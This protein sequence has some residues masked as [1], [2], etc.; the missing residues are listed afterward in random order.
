MRIYNTA[1]RKKEELIPLE[2]GH[3]KIYACGPT[4]YDLM[5][6]GNAR[7]IITFDALRRYLRYKGYKVTYV[8]NF[9]D[10]DDKMIA[11]SRQKG[12][13]VRELADQMIEEYFHDADS[14][15][16]MR[17]DVHPRATESIPAIIDLITSL[18][19]KGHAYVADDGVYFEVASF[20]DYGKLSHHNLED[21]EEGAS[22]RVTDVEGKRSALDFVLWKFKKEGE[23]SWDSPW[24]AGRPGWHIECSAMSQEN[25]GETI[26]IHSG[27]VDLVFPHHENEIAQSEAASGKPFVRYWMHNGFINVNQIKMSK[28]KGNFF[29]V[30]KLAELYPYEIIRYYILQSHYR[31]PINFTLSDDEDE[32]NPM[33]A[34][35]TSYRRIR[36]SLQTLEFVAETAAEV[37]DKEIDQALEE[38]IATCR[39]EW[40]EAMD[41]DLNTADA[42]AAIFDL[43]R[44]ANTAAAS[45]QASKTQ[46]LNARKT[47][48]ELCH[49]L[50]L[51]PDEQEEI[52]IPTEVKELVEQRTKAKQER[53]FEEADRL[54]DEVERLGFRLEDTPQGVNIH[55]LED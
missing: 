28:S 41:D 21:L 12:I 47:I 10:I 1:S 8:Q 33:D 13:T 55:L 7:P 17:A 15:N 50:G 40:T 52:I 30:R 44:A 29:L 20:E 31:M 39:R 25:L 54:R 23:P 34:A 3:F 26:D 11:R 16:V 35:V 14:L 6:L 2:E 36:T 27:G 5:H 37:G 46:L 43:V 24:G 49:V 22:E 45:G 4:V 9:T 42:I 18:Y 38:A 32:D 19:E 51:K 53:N 48:I